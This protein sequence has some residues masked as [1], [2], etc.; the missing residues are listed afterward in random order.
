MVKIPLRSLAV[1]E[2]NVSGGTLM[3]DGPGVNGPDLTIMFGVDA[4]TQKKYHSE[5]HVSFQRLVEALVAL[6][7][8]TWDGDD[9]SGAAEVLRRAAALFFYW[10]NLTPLSRGSSACGYGALFAAVLATGRVIGRPVPKDKQLDFEAFFS[11]SPDLFADVLSAWFPE[12][13]LASP[14]LRQWVKGKEV[15]KEAQEEEVEVRV[16]ASS[17]PLNE[18]GEEG[19]VVDEIFD[20]TGAILYVLS[21]LDEYRSSLY[22]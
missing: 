20:T 18:E 11:R 14:R 8:R 4:P 17:V 12:L 13:P 10:V 15:T 7:Q 21:H 3:V 16:D 6:P 1:P 5:L 9:E 19:L 2:K 22:E